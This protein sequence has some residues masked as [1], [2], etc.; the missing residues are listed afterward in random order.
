MALQTRDAFA[1]RAFQAKLGRI[2][3]K[4]EEQKEREAR[5][6]RPALHLRTRL[7]WWASL[8]RKFHHVVFNNVCNNIRDFSPI[9]LHNSLNR[10]RFKDKIMQ[11]FKVLER[12]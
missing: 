12:P 4:V 5:R 3:A 7:L 2:P 10:N 9:L 8:L 11:H 6:R 1:D